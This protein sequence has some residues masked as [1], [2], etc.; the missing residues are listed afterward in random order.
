MK[1]SW[2]LL[3]C[4]AILAACAQEKNSTN[5]TMDKKMITVS[6]VA[7]NGKGNALLVTEDSTVYYIEGMDSW[8][9]NVVGR[10]IEI[11]GVSQLESMSE[12]DLKNEQG[13]YKQSVSG[14]K[15]I[16]TNVQWKGIQQ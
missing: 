2:I 3:S 1:H 6:G 5:K 9:T 11:T 16:L 15:R 13:E 7:Q 8:E 12:G 10:K 14:E 4:F